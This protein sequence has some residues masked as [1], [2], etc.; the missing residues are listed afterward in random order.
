MLNQKVDAVLPS[1]ICVTALLLIPFGSAW[2]QDC[3]NPSACED[4]DGNG[5]VDSCQNSTTLG[6]GL[7]GAYYRA[8][9]AFPSGA[10]IPV[11]YLL[12]QV[13]A[14]LDFESD[15]N[16]PPAGVPVDHFMVRWTGTL[17]PTETGVHQLRSR[18]DDGFR[19]MVDGEY[20]LEAW[21]DSGGDETLASVELEAGVPVIICAEYYE[22]AGSDFCELKW[23]LPSFG[24]EDEYVII[25]S[26]VFTP[27]TDIDGDGY[28]DFEVED[29]NGNGLSDAVEIG[30]GLAHDCDANCV[31]DDCDEIEYEVL[32]W[33]RFQSS[34]LLL[35][36]SSGNGRHLMGSSDVSFS[37]DRAV[38]FIPRTGETNLGSAE[39]RNSGH[40]RF[41]DPTGVFALGEESFTVETWI[42]LDSNSNTDDAD[43]RQYLLQKKNASGD[44]NAGFQILA[45][46]GNIA[47]A[48]NWFGKPSDRTGNELAIRFGN[49]TIS[50][51]LI[52]RLQLRVCTAWQH[53]SVTVDQESQR[54]RFEVNGQ[55]EWQDLPGLGHVPG[56]GALRIG[57]H[58]TSSGSIDQELDGNIDELRIIRG[59][60]P[61]SAMLDRATAIDECEIVTCPA[62]YDG[63]DSVDG[64]DLTQLLGAWGSK[65]TFLDL[66]GD[67]VITGA[68][69]TLLLGS[70]G[71]CQ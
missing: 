45:Q 15:P 17:T 71:P 34:S 26:A 56:S 46:C 54:V 16:F 70:W 35:I 19:L 58:S 41:S 42:K 30:T 52:S 28:P 21:F 59:V 7:I 60:L 61:L 64:A 1:T 44:V 24:P 6:N 55:V 12:S 43:R 63:N 31:P 2:S 22:N 53:M 57:A 69:L 23:K 49:G 11:E 68:D 67:G 4:F 38:G 50:Y 48:G 36:D 62:D 5:V 40:L 33:Y 14:N 8:C 39:F 9:D 27:S 51:T 32:A 25:P 47:A 37:S 10:V 29:C 20:V 18:S 3:F 65:N 66:D 13:D